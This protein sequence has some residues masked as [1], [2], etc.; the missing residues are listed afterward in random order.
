M[1]A[2]DEVVNESGLEG[3][4]GLRSTEPSKPS[5]GCPVCHGVTN[6]AAAGRETFQ[7][8]TVHRTIW[9]NVQLPW[10]VT[11]EQVARQREVWQRFDLDSFELVRPWS[12]LDDRAASA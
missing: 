4:L 7:F 9:P 1:K 10:S 3:P 12:I 6:N 2:F 5:V 11:V 8:C